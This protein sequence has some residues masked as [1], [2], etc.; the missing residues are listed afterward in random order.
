MSDL[1]NVI[2]GESYFAKVYEAVPDYNEKQSPGTGKYQWEITV[3]GEPEV[4][5][6]F[7]AAGF[8][9]GVR[10]NKGGM[11]DYSDKPVITFIKWA[12][13][14]KGNE[15]EPP[16]VMDKDK[17]EFEE[18]I[19]NGSKVRIQWEPYKYGEN[20]RHLRPMLL[21]VQVLEL[22][23]QSMGNITADEVAF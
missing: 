2:Q 12:T 9:A 10:L 18:R 20:G 16:L 4:Y 5:E 14:K 11:M 15:N 21:A 17:K 19:E 1:S 22:F 8:N 3:A 23:E 7:K 6:Q 13:D